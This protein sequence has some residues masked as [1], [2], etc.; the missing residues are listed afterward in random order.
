MKNISAVVA[1]FSLQV[2]LASA[3]FAGQAVQAPG[4]QDVLN[5]AA[6]ALLRL[7]S[8]QFFVKREGPPAFMDEENGITFAGA[9]CSYAA[10]DRVSC[11]IKVSLKNQTVV[12]LTRVWVP[13]G[14]FQTN[15]L[16]RQ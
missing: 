15:P 5:R 10:P 12:Q 2:S 9:Q 4:P 16:T 14:V 13:E 1:L 8:A 11:D 7:K 3:T 6:D